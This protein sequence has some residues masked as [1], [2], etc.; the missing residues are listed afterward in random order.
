[1]ATIFRLPQVSTCVEADASTHGWHV[2]TR[3][4]GS[5]LYWRK[6]YA[7][8]SVAKSNASEL[9]AERNWRRSV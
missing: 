9:A 7:L 2:R 1:M 8:L 5:L 6:S 3:R 4:G